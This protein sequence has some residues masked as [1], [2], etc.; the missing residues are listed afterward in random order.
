MIR[1][2]LNLD[3]ERDDLHLQSQLSPTP[4]WRLP[5]YGRPQ[6]A[7]LIPDWFIRWGLEEMV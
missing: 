1:A 5:C 2:R 6:R 7:R 4:R 3:A